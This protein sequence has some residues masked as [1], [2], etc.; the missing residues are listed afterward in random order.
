MRR[1]LA[2]AI[3]LA[4]LGPAHAAM[5]EAEAQAIL[6]KSMDANGD[7]AVTPREFETFRRQ[8][9][10]AMDADGDSR[11]SIQEWGSFD[12]GF[13]GI[14]EERGAQ[15]QLM[16]AKD[17]VFQRYNVSGDAYLSNEEMMAGLFRDFLEA[18]GDDD[19]RLT[20]TE[21]ASLRLLKSFADALMQ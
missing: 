13:L 4:A 15:M 10:T 20:E 12:P 21:S 19:G 2:L 5:S 3:T 1:L 14:A 7:A 18:D 9:M 8:A 6:F 17:D 11:V 16:D